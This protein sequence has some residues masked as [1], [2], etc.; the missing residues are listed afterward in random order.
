MC[1]ATDISLV[2][3]DGFVRWCSSAAVALVP[4]CETNV[5]QLLI[6]SRLNSNVCRAPVRF[7]GDIGD[8]IFFL[9]GHSRGLS[10]DRTNPSIVSTA[11]KVQHDSACQSGEC[12]VLPTEIV[13]TDSWARGCDQSFA[14]AGIWQSARLISQHRFSTANFLGHSQMEA[15]IT[16]KS[17][18]CCRQLH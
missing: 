1:G 4:Y 8:H 14:R 17:V 15:H 9:G 12:L 7:N 10:K 11:H 2:C 3:D 6:I 13:R 16:L 5:T 18:L